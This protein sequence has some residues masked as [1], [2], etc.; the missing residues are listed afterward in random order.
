MQLAAKLPQDSEIHFSQLSLWKKALKYHNTTELVC[1]DSSLR[2][3]ASFSFSFSKL[4]G[5]K[6]H[7]AD[8][9][10]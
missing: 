5:H 1:S 2:H 7:S 9:D 3:T 8:D 10:D 4:A 6:K